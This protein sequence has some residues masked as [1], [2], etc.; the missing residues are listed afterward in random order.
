MSGDE[1][2]QPDPGD[3]LPLSTPALHIL[4]ALGWE[5]MHGYAVMQGIEEK[6]EGRARILPGTLYTTLNRMV[7]DGL[8][9]EASA[10]P[11][12]PDDDRR[13]RYYR[14]TEFGRRVAAAEVDRM[15]LLMDVARRDLLSDGGA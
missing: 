15:A 11:D 1:R 2:R 5:R 9:E 6:T 8:V 3:L 4:L 14:V 12:E 7:E 10:P 13:R